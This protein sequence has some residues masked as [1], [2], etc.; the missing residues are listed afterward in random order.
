V[1]RSLVSAVDAPRTPPTTTSTLLYEVILRSLKTLA[2]PEPRSPAVR[3][4]REA[5]WERIP[6]VSAAPIGNG[7]LVWQ[8]GGSG[9][10][11]VYAES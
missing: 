2:P 3:L 7:E 5:G 9:V 6:S 4:V 10:A 8:E 1:H 11:N